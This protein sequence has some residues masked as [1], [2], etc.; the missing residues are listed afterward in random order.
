MFRPAAYSM[1]HLTMP[2]KTPNLVRLL[3]IMQRLRSPHGCPWDREQTHRTLRRHLVE[4]TYEVIDAI[5]A[6]N[7]AALRE[8]LGDLLL[9]VVFHA[10]LAR[11][12][13][14]FNFDD[15]AGAIADKL[16]HR[17]PHVFGGQK[18]KTS[19][20]VLQQ[21]EVIKQGEKAGSSSILHNLP[22]ALPAL[23]KAE[24]VQ[25]KVAHVGFDW[26]NVKDVVAKVEEEL[27]E[28]KHAM[29]TGNRKNFEEELGDLLFATVN[30]A[31]YEGLEAED[32]L[33][34]TIR[35]FTKRF[36]QVE[37]AIHKQGRRLEDCT[38]EELDALWEKAKRRRKKP[39]PRRKPSS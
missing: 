22:R 39:T 35:K 4:E 9:Q 13:K 26:H 25:K 16:V 32:L 34:R 33:H 18:L 38:L 6:G 21:W 7:H 29:A 23:M 15:V 37:R 20:Q 12:A 10:Q 5:E 28:L 8:E 11:E 3:Q 17:H 19:D 36:Q 24:K 27:H 2:T 31:R 30:L 1:P 14:H